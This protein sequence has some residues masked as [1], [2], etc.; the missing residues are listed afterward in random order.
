MKSQ[1]GNALFLILIA[2]ALF[3]AL[4]Y[5]ITTSSRGGG[6]SIARE[7]TQLKASQM[8]QYAQAVR[9][10]VQK[11]VLFGTPVASINPWWDSG[12]ETALFSRAGGGVT[13][14]TANVG[15]AGLPNE[16][17]DYYF[18]MP[19]DNVAVSGVGTAA[20]EMLMVVQFR[21]NAEGLS[22]CQAINN[23][24]KISGVPGS[25]IGPDWV[26][27]LPGT[28]VACVRNWNDFYIFYV[29]VHE[30]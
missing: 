8:V 24:L 21:L 12:Q 19:S 15:A 20:P 7:T 30:G 1:R 10:G 9:S 14:Q 6:S 22:L 2:V 11:M 13:K 17:A 18:S 23:V 4:S 25:A 26:S 5:A 29:A 28:P 16:T 3:G 27:A